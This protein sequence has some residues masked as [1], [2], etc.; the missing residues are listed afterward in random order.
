MNDQTRDSTVKPVTSLEDTSLIA[1]LKLKG[2]ILIPW[3]SRDDPSD[4]RV[5]FDIQGNELQIE[6]DMQT[7]YDNEQVGIQDFC[8]NLKEVKS[9]MYNLKRIKT[10]E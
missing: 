2:H 10:R 3:I 8:R 7:F 4:I 9:T 1:Y 6:K 5:S